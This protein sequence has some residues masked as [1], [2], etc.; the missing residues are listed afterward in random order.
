M[1]A[2]RAAG[3]PLTAAAR[4][5]RRGGN[6]RPAAAQPP[7]DQRQIRQLGAPPGSWVHRR[8]RSARLPWMRPPLGR[9]AARPVDR[10][11]AATPVRTAQSPRPPRRRMDAPQV[12]SVTRRPAIR[13]PTTTRPTADHRRP[14]RSCRSRRSASSSRPIPTTSWRPTRSTG[15]ARACSRAATTRDAAEEFLAGYKAYPKSAA[16]P[17]RCST[18]PSRLPG[19]VTAMRRARCMRWRLKQVSADVEWRS[20]S[21]SS[22]NKPVPA[23]DVTAPLADAELDAL[24]APLADANAIALAVSGGADSSR[25]SMPSTAGAGGRDG[26]GVSCS[27]SIIGCAAG[28]RARRPPS[29]RSPRRG[30][31]QPGCWPGRARAR[32]PTSKRRRG[33]ARYRLLF[34]ACREEG[35]T[36]LV[37]AHHRDDRRR[38]VP[39]ALEARRRRLRPRGD[40][41]G[42]ARRWRHDRPAVPRRSARTRLAAT[43]AAAGWTPVDDPMNADPRFARRGC[44]S[45]CRCSLARGSTRA[46]T[47]RDRL[48]SRRRRRCD[49][50]GG[51]RASRR[52]GRRPMRSLSRGSIRR[53][54]AA[55]RRRS[56]PRCLSALLL[57][58]GGDD[59]PP[60]YERLA[61]LCARSPRH[62]ARP[63]QA[64]AWRR[65]RRVA[66]TGAFAFY[67]ES[68]RDGLPGDARRSRAL[69]AS[70]TIALRSR[71]GKDAPAGLTLGALGEAG[72]PE[73]GGRRGR[74]SG[75]R[76]RGPPGAPPAGRRSSR[77]RHFG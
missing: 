45:S 21:G 36:H 54:F 27:P 23:A 10:S 39:D 70:G 51:D 38:D 59:Y 29:R 19:S 68:G 71:S 30:A 42:I 55:R 22:P 25:C 63:L 16:R 50:R 20:A 32:R 47:R 72:R 40:A 77:C 60:R 8:R 48:A 5:R 57:A 76:A 33:P 66:R 34:D 62:A 46:A 12:A 61:A 2:G 43:T 65:G 31:W 49:R 75:R 44:G 73:V 24:F 28:R 67:R 26:P 11:L 56:A 17:T 58:V 35:A 15:S 41:P 52:G 4:S 6:R 14:L 64:H 13:A 53:A 37:I 3:A 74:L 7:I 1:K 18:R 9:A 69:P